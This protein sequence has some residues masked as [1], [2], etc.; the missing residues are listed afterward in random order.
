MKTI[1]RKKIQPLTTTI[2]LLLL[3]IPVLFIGEFALRDLVTRSFQDARNMRVVDNQGVLIIRDQLDEETGMRGYAATHQKIFLEPYRAARS[4]MAVDI[5]QFV[6][7]LKILKLMRVSSAISDAR[8]VNYT[9][10]HTVAEPIIAGSTDSEVLQLR[11]KELVDRFRHD[12]R[13]IYVLIHEKEQAIDEE[14]KSSIDRISL[15]LFSSVVAIV[16]IA[17]VFSGRQDRLFRRLEGEKRSSA[18]LRV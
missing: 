8:S 17:L 11:G 12:I 4:R 1:T 13:Q 2:L 16:L 18:D 10:L 3:V 15:L 6:T 7:E 14:A 9:W 5:D